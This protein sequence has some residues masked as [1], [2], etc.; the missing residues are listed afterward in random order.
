MEAESSANST[1]EMPESDRNPKHKSL[2]TSGLVSIISVFVTQ[3]TLFLLPQFLPTLSLLTLLPLSALLIVVVMGLGRCCKKVL[4]VRASAP[5]FVFFSIFFTWAVYIYV[6][7]QVISP[8]MDIVFNIEIVTV[9][10]GLLG[11]MSVD[12]GFVKDQSCCLN[13]VVKSYPNEVEEDGGQGSLTEESFTA[14]RR[15]RYCRHC[16]N[17]I[18]GFD[19][20]CPAFGNCI[21]TAKSLTSTEVGRESTAYRN[22]VLGTMLFS[23]IQVVWQVVFIA[24]HVYCACFNIKTDE[25][26]NWE[27]YPEFH[28]EVIPSSGV[29]QTVIQFKN[30]YDKGIVNNLKDFIAAKE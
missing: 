2:I 1:E 24:W 8:V 30:P 9:V 23:L 5:A 21:D 19:H 26:I 11:I 29:T 22:L 16:D 18:M 14:L 28:V 7:R 12:P 27:K 4:G 25:W 10:I 15:V 20:H 17:Y 6:V 13:T 3:L